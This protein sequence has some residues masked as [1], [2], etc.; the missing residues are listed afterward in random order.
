MKILITTITMIFIS[1]GV[2]GDGTAWNVGKLYERCKIIND[3]DFNFEE[4]DKD[5]TA[6][7]VSCISILIT[8][9]VEGEK[10][11]HS[12]KG[13]LKNLEPSYVRG[14]ILGRM[15]LFGNSLT[16]NQ[17]LIKTFVKWAKNK[18]EFWKQPITNSQPRMDF[19]GGNFPCKPDE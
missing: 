3:A 16:D 11:C 13:T 1:F 6:Y 4:L 12:L 18:Q 14:E 8:M 5:K 17:N 15:L 2:L 19:F 9:M 7:S 10:I